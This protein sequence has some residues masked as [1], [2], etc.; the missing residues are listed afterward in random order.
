MTSQTVVPSNFRYRQVPILVSDTP[1]KDDKVFETFADAKAWV[2]EVAT[3][4]IEQWEE[5]RDT[6]YTYEE[7]N[8]AVKKIDRAKRLMKVVKKMKDPTE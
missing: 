5:Y 6:C 2:L 4:D 8:F 7:G 3:R 1:A